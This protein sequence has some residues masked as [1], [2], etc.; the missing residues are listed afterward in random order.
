MSRIGTGQSAVTDTSRV[1]KPILVSSCLLGL[2]TRYDATDNYCQEVIDHL[3]DNRLTPIP[4]CPEQLAGL[5]TPR[6]KC[7]FV[8]GDGN[9]VVAGS[10]QLTDENGIDVTRKFLHGALET[11]KIAQL[12]GC[13]EAILQQRSPSC[14]S[15]A[16]YLNETLVSGMG[17]TTAVL[18]KNGIIVRGN[19]TFVKKKS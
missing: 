3:R 19:E 15:T 16:I 11:L 7:W 14:G 17:V 18:N 13:S 12:T 10:G 2:R 5:P 4:V 8:H 6:P 1:M 9:D